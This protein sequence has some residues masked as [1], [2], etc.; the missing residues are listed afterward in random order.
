MESH[1]SSKR[2]LNSKVIIAA[3]VGSLLL[4]LV[5]TISLHKTVVVAIEGQEIQVSTLASTVEGVLRKEGI[6]IGEADRTVPELNQRVKDG[7]RIVIH[8]AY[9]IQLI[10]SGNTQSIITA[11]ETVKSL[12]QSLNIELQDMDIVEPPLGVSIGEG[13]TVKITRVT[14]E[15]TAET[16][17]I[18]Y[19]TVIK[20]NNEMDYGKMNQLQEGKPGLQEVKIAI[21]YED[22]EEVERS[23]IEEYVTTEAVNEIMERGTANL[24]ATSR[25]NSRYT[26]ALTMTATAYDAGYESTGKRPGDQYYGVT[27]SGTQVRPGVVAV[28]PNVI[29]LGTK[30][31][32]ESTD[33][34]GNYGYAS[35]EDTGG[36]IKGNKIDLYY[37]SRSEALRFGRRTVKVYVLE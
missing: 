14:E 37:E 2:L 3:I 6:E 34:T 23:I 10:E 8:R 17:E 29:P 21:R 22:G 12:L 4:I 30:L 26:K 31:Y 32:I 24:I 25:G 36:A 15:L 5:G 11:V 20:H 7:E 35:A 33:G 27:R 9:E 16:Q 1:Q 28:D 19:Q 13:D 18:P